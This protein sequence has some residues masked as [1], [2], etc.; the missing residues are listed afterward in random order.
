[1]LERLRPA[2]LAGKTAKVD[3]RSREFRRGSAVT[4]GSVVSETAADT[5][6][7]LL[8]ALFAAFGAASYG[9]TIVLGRSLAKA[10]LG[11]PTVLSI[12][13]L[14]AAVILLGLQYSL[15]RGS[16]ARGELVRLL[17]LGVVYAIESTL[18]FMALERGTAAAVALL[19]YSYPVIVTVLEVAGGAGR[20]S[21]AV[22]GALAASVVGSALVAVAGAG[23][24]VSITTTGIALALLSAV[25]FSFYLLA[26]DRVVPRSDALAKAAWV[27]LGCGLTHLV[28]GVAGG[29][30]HSPW[31]HVPALVANG[32]AT[33]SA[34]AFMFA[35]LH[36]LGA[37]RTAV[38][39]TLE[40]V[41]AIVLAAI[42][43]GEELGALQIVGGAAI[44]AGAVVVALS[45][46][47]PVPEL[48]DANAETP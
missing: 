20:P 28:R 2:T 46:R 21:T 5:R 17:V 34:F 39:M 47:A 10:R 37:S 26:T 44:L 41:F 14:L 9:T 42:F 40:A 29:A 35:G 7:G 12:R 19:F 36:L 3:R 18:F 31:G 48:L 23:A 15:R 27:A 13:F 38:V 22:L 45:P 8:G 6:N 33:A 43:L 16:G 4:V 11:A 32:V 25:S 24:D 30:L 1:M